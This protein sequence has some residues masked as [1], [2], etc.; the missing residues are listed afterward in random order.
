[1][2]VVILAGGF[3]TRLSEETHTIPKPMVSVGSAP[4]LWHIMKIY[5]AAGFNEFVVL[6]G[7]KGYAIKEY[8]KNYFW[9]NSD[10]TLDLASNDVQFHNNRT[11]N[12]KV[13][14]VDTGENTMTGGRVLRAADFL[15]DERFLLTYGDGVG[16]IDFKSL[17]DFHKAHGKIA[18]MTSVQPDGRFGTFNEEGGQVKAFLEKPKGDGSWVNGG[19]FVLEPEF[20]NYI[21]EGDSTVLEEG[22]LENLAKDGELMVHR[23]TG[24]WKCMDTLKD[25][26]DLQR[27]WDTGSAPWK[28]WT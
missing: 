2:K 28:V 21:Q 1:M 7:Y 19:F 23:H 25:K 14:L 17:V 24:F 12:W 5:S 4:I 18:T 16:N 20:L 13:T 9:H 8:F 6:L 11:E 22:P 27:M 3:G 10:V 26:T 15:G